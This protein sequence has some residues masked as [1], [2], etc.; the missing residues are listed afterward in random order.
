MYLFLVAL[1]VWAGVSIGALLPRQDPQC[2]FAIAASGGVSGIVGQLYDGQV[3][4][5]PDFGGG[6]FCINNGAITDS[7]GRGCI[8]T[9]PTTQLQCDQGAVPS[10]GFSISST[11]QILYGGNPTFYACPV[12]DKGNYNIYSQTLTD[13]PKCTQVQLMSNNQACGSGSGSGSAVAPLVVGGGAMVTPVMGP[14]VG[15]AYSYPPTTIVQGSS[16]SVETEIST[17]T[18][19][20]AS[21]SSSIC[22]TSIY[23]YVPYKSSSAP[24]T[25]PAETSS[26]APSTGGQTTGETPSGGEQPA[27][28]FSE[29]SQPL[30][31]AVA[32]ASGG[33]ATGPS[34][35]S[36]NTVGGPPGS[37]GS[38]PNMG[39]MESQSPGTGAQSPSAGD[40]PQ[41]GQAPSGQAASAVSPGNSPS[42]GMPVSSPIMGPPAG[43][44]MPAVPSTSTCPTDLEGK[45]EFPHSIQVVDSVTKKVIVAQSYNGIVSAE[46]DS[47]FTFDIPYNYIGLT[48]S[49]IFF[50]P[51][52]NQL[53]TSSYNQSNENGGQINIDVLTGPL[54]T[55][56]TVR[57]HHAVN[58]APG[59]TYVLGGYPCP[60]GRTVTFDMSS[61]GGYSLSYFQDYNPSPIGLYV[62]VC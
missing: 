20:L 35:S 27:S 39:G 21:G 62:R 2:C 28:G 52:R 57:S 19:T 60:A 30:A 18:S 31:P 37:G 12:D 6:T 43:S 29:S 22:S 42:G 33:E 7:Q 51:E 50:F 13:M 61:R 48:C 26:G 46:K 44:G 25:S 11:S 10:I 45:F 41:A 17:V 59:N 53:V 38:V 1:A 8:L 9:Y 54:S 24:P 55:S 32:P 56:P 3:R 14:P 49:G 58:V 5:G 36:P 40:Q 4:V 23:P 34:S 16:T 15:G 47:I